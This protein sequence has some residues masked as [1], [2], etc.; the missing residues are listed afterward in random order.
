MNQRI[1]PDSTHTT[2]S[3]K[4]AATR[5]TEL[6]SDR[7]LGREPR[8]DAGTP[9][10]DHKVVAILNELHRDLSGWGER[11]RSGGERFERRKPDER[12]FG[13]GEQSCHAA[14]AEA[15]GPSADTWWEP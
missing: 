7:G 13:Q 3:Q 14:A 12:V 8:L 10:A 4:E 11:V 9:L 2:A 5:W 6:S 15:A 1:T